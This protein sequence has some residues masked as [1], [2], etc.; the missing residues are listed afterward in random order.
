VF[1]HV[2]PAPALFVTLFTKEQGRFLQNDMF[3]TA[4]QH[5]VE[6]LHW[7]KPHG[8]QLQDTLRVDHLSHYL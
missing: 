2:A 3:L 4:G 7:G 6:F 8:S 1:L 5:A